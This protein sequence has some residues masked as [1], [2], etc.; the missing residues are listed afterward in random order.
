MGMIAKAHVQGFE[1]G[2]EQKTIAKVELVDYPDSCDWCKGSGLTLRIGY[3]R[4]CSK[5]G[6]EL[7]PNPP[8]KYTPQLTAITANSTTTYIERIHWMCWGQFHS[9]YASPGSFLK[10][11][12]APQ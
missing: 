9:Y 2:D 3:K 6:K 12:K 1:A 7:P 8:T 11:G 10:G 4:A 5:L